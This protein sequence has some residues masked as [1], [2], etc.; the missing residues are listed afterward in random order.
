MK[1]RAYSRLVAKV[2]FIL[3]LPRLQ[4]DRPYW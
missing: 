4:A 3:I 2:D 1:I